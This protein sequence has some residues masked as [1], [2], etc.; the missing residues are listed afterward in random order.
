MAALLALAVSLAAQAQGTL[1]G[2]VFDPSNSAVPKAT[3]TVTGPGGVVKVA[4]TNDDGEFSISGLPTGQ[5]TIRVIA[6]GFG[7][8]EKAAVA[9]A[10]GK[11]TAFDAKLSVE[12]SKQEVT[13]ADT[14]QVELDPA[15][16]AGA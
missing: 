2:H 9:V 3:V 13:V 12:V 16:N 7:L 4:T 11:P 14:Q 15:K 10:A 1:T 5:Y 8:F 6:S